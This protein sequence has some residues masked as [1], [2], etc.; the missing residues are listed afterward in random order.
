MVMK[1]NHVSTS[2]LTSGVGSNCAG[3]FSICESSRP[4]AATNAS[5]TAWLAACRPKLLP[6]ISSGVATGF[7]ASDITQN[8][9]FWYWAPMITNSPPAALAADTRSGAL[10]PTSAVPDETSISAA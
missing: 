5:H 3:N 2:P 7:V 4:L 8:G 9:F 6:Y 10:R 1:L